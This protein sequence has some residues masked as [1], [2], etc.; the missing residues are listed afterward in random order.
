MPKRPTKTKKKDWIF[1]EVSRGEWKATGIN[2]PLS[3]TTHS[4]YERNQ[5][6]SLSEALR[7]LSEIYNSPFHRATT[8]VRIR[9]VYTNEEINGEIFS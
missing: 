8:I 9:N 3:S 5:K 2:L 6:F 1:E 7:I 4:Y